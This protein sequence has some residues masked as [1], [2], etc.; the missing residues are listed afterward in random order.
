MALSSLH[1]VIDLEWLKEAYRLTRKD[2]APGIDGVMANEYAA[3]LEANLLDLLDR[4]KSGRYKAPPVRRTYIPKTDGS[5]RP[6]GIPTFEDKVAQRAI[7]MVLEA[8]YEQDFLSCSYGFRPGRAAHQAL[9]V[10]RTAIMSQRLRWVLDIDIVKYFDSISH[11]HLRDFLDRRVTDGVIRRMIDKWLKAG[12]LEDGLLRHA[13]EGSPQGG[14]ISPCL[15]NIFLHHVLDEWFELEVRPRL[16]GRCTLVRFADDAVMAFE[17]SLD[18]KRVLGVLGKRLARYGLTLHLDKTRFVDF[19]DNRPNGTN[20][21]E[22]DSTSFTFL[23]FTHAWGKAYRSVKSRVATSAAYSSASVR[24]SPTSRSGRMCH[25]AYFNA[26]IASKRLLGP[27]TRPGSALTQAALERHQPPGSLFLQ[28]VRQSGNCPAHR[29]AAA[30]QLDPLGNLAGLCAGEIKPR[31]AQ[32][33]V[34]QDNLV[35]WRHLR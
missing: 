32:P 20:H 13:T 11:S 15:S 31:L 19:R 10:L 24:N 29:A 12:V 16:K 23:G 18:A 4:I 27:L 17:E 30:K 9:Q 8:V 14:V 5:R 1:H 22:T 3:N 2:G 25:G 6:L 26:P 28:T 21:P 35:A 7:V 33:P 34:P